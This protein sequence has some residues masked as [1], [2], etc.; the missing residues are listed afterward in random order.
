MISV[1]PN[2]DCINCLGSGIDYDTYGQ[3]DCRCIMENVRQQLRKQ[4]LV[5]LLVARD[6]AVAIQVYVEVE[7]VCGL[8]SKDSYFDKGILWAAERAGK[9]PAPVDVV[10]ELFGGAP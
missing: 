3:I 6:W 8:D 2:P 1:E 10:E 9:L 5:R 4:E 7:A